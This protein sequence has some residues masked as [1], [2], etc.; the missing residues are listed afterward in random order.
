MSPMLEYLCLR[1]ITRSRT[2]QLDKL[3][4]NP[5]TGNAYYEDQ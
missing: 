1:D 3:M 2:E 5:A 4:S